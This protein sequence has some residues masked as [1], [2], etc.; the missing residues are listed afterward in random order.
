MSYQAR[1]PNPTATE[2]NHKLRATST[3]KL[4]QNSKLSGSVDEFHKVTKLVYYQAC[5][6]ELVSKIYP[7]IN[8][9]VKKRTR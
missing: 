2:K 1:F 7:H 9:N 3:I 6:L 8:K 4:V 5:E